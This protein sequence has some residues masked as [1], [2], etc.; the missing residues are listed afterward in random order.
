MVARFRVFVPLH[1]ESDHPPE[2]PRWSLMVE[3]MLMA[4]VKPMI[5]PIRARF[6]RR[7]YR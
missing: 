4:Y 6:L 1:L 7:P 5:D 2:R 3:P